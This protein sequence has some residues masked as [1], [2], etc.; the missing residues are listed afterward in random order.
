MDAGSGEVDTVLEAFPVV[1]N[2][3]LRAVLRSSNHVLSSPFFTIS[4]FLPAM[5]SVSNGLDFNPFCFIGSSIIE[6]SLENI[7]LCR[8][9]FRKLIPLEIKFPLIASPKFFITL[10]AT[11]GSKMIGA[12]IV[13]IFGFYDCLFFLFL[14]FLMSFI[15]S[16]RDF[17]F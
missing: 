3:S 15:T 6:I 14:V 12:F 10:A 16:K 11:R 4:N 2:P 13:L 5:P 17:D 7:S 1:F 9:L 8:S